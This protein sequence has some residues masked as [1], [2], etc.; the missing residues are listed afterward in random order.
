[1]SVT[2]DEAEVIRRMSKEDRRRHLAA[3]MAGLVKMAE[4]AVVLSEEGED[5]VRIEALEQEKAALTSSS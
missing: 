3:N 1:M 2:A 5:P 4:M